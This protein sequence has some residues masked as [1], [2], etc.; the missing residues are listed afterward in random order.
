MTFFA[1]VA[2]IMVV[3]V[4]ATEVFNALHIAKLRRSGRYPERGKATM[5]DVE[6]LLNMGSRV[7]AV[8]CYRE[9]HGCSL[10]EASE[11]VSTLAI[12]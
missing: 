8:R 10:R 7:L 12:K 2:L 6:R 11:A 5:A 3:L 9:I 1:W 4:G